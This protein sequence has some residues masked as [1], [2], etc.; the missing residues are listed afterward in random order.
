MRSQKK[1]SNLRVPEVVSLK[2]IIGTYVQTDAGYLQNVVL[3][4][5]KAQLQFC[6]LTYFASQNIS[7]YAKKQILN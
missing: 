7:V 1:F 3:Q 5:N 6:K 4:K 2:P